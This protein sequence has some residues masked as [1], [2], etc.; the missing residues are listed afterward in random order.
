[1]AGESSR[2]IKKQN[3]GGKN[4][5]AEAIRTV[6]QNYK[7]SPPPKITITNGK[8]QEPEGVGGQTEER[9]LTKD[10][11]KVIDAEP[12]SEAESVN[13][14][15]PVNGA[16]PVNEAG[17]VNGAGAPKMSMDE[18]KEI[19]RKFCE[20][21][22][23]GAGS[24][25]GEPPRTMSVNKMMSRGCTVCKARTMPINDFLSGSNRARHLDTSIAPKKQKP[26]VFVSLGTFLDNPRWENDLKKSSPAQSPKSD[27]YNVPEIDKPLSNY[28]Y[29]LKWPQFCDRSL[30]PI[31][32]LGNLIHDVRGYSDKL[33]DQDR[34]EWKALRPN[35]WLPIL[36]DICEAAQIVAR[37]ERTRME[38]DLQN[39]NKIVTMDPEGL[40]DWPICKMGH[41]SRHDLHRLLVKYE[42]VLESGNLEHAE[43]FDLDLGKCKCFCTPRYTQRLLSTDSLPPYS[44]RAGPGRLKRRAV[45][46][47][48]ILPRPLHGKVNSSTTKRYFPE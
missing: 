34:A 41:H 35:Y 37:K 21:P 13:E 11:E 31:S 10:E 44:A 38:R 43:K 6:L 42:L 47:G 12:V 40:F 20:E 27:L 5:W 36:E 1:M 23:N 3:K 24:T 22:A 39:I 16:G 26:P 48:P 15:E 46:V 18:M 29:V 8:S 7:D 14:A 30:V 4:A 45:H 25:N 32:L 28:K 9:R 17:P 33:I 2:N 19:V